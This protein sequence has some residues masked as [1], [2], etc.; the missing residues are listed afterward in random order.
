MVGVGTGETEIGPPAGMM[1]ATPGVDGVEAGATAGDDD[2]WGV[3]VLTGATSAG[4]G[5]GIR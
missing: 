3:G 5:V 1:G 2:E 4:P